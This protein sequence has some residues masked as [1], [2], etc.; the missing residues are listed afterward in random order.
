MTTNIG[1]TTAKCLV[2]CDNLWTFELY[3]PRY[4]HSEFMTHRVFSRN[5]SSSR[6]IPV[7]RMLEQ[8]KDTPVIPP[9][10][11]MNEKGMAGT[12]EADETTTEAFYK[13]WLEARNNACAVA[14]EM[15]RLG[16][17]KQH[18]NRILEPFQFIKVIVTGTEWSNF[19]N[20]RIAPDAQPEMQ[21]LALAIKNEMTNSQGV[22]IGCRKLEQKQVSL[23][24]ITDEDYLEYKLGRCSSMD[25]CKASAARCARVSYNNHDGSKPNIEKD[26]K[27]F[28]HLLKHKHLTPMEHVCFKGDLDYLKFAP[29]GVILLFIGIGLIIV[30]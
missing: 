11:F 20:L 23:P 2:H 25:L 3:Y 13:L 29:L 7:K 9:I 16:L 10:V 12:V 6:A 24:Y 21:M 4:I 17:H 14:E 8:V 22:T 27:L 19:F 30:L 26:L 28:E 5:A 1:N 15:E 18:I